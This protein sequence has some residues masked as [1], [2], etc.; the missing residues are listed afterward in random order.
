[1]SESLL[2]DLNDGVLLLTLNRPKKKNALDSDLF[3]AIGHALD[4]ARKDGAVHVVVLTGAGGNFCSGM[5]LTASFS[6]EGAKPF[7][8]C[9]AAVVA[10]L[11]SPDS[12]H[13]NGE[14]IRVDGG[15][16]A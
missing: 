2:K 13:I 7:G 9:A 3:R 6:D 1:M 10:F 8:E 12:A 5:D 15:T 16:L 14:S 4:D 11:A